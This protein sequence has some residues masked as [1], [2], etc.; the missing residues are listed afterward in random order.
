MD[1]TLI[2]LPIC[3]LLNNLHWLGYLLFTNYHSMR[4]VANPQ[5]NAQRMNRTFIATE[6]AKRWGGDW[7]WILHLVN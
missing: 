7:I 3:Y 2:L 1:W 5:T 4:Q 6:L